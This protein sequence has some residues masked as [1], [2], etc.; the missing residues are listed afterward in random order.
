MRLT[1]LGAL[2]EVKQLSTFVVKGAELLIA[3]H[4]RPR[5][6]SKSHAF[7]APHALSVQC[8]GPGVGGDH[9]QPH[10]LR[11]LPFAGCFVV[12]LGLLVD[13]S[14]LCSQSMRALLGGPPRPLP[15]QPRNDDM[16]GSNSSDSSLA[17]G[18]LASPAG[19]S[20]TEPP[21]SD[22]L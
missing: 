9:S 20:Q 22:R 12:R 7:N 19:A 8:A 3:A 2:S 4:W 6:T 17:S 21:P 5:S 13:V 14:T 15:H 10:A 16:V 1:P 11:W 18:S